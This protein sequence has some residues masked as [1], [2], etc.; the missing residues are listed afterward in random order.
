MTSNPQTGVTWITSESSTTENDCILH[1]WRPLELQFG[2]TDIDLYLTDTLWGNS[3]ADIRHQP[4]RYPKKILLWLLTDRPYASIWTFHRLMDV[5]I[6]GTA[7]SFPCT[8]CPLVLNAVGS[9]VQ[10]C[11]W[12]YSTLSLYITV[13]PRPAGVFVIVSN[14]SSHRMPASTNREK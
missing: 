6:R 7:D 10:W 12:A 3:E 13:V 8:S 14:T 2:T 4:H 1:T 5:F 9:V 11:I